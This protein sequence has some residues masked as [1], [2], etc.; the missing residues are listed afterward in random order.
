MDEILEWLKQ[1]SIAIASIPEGAYPE[2]DEYLNTAYYL[3]DDAICQLKAIV[4]PEA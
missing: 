4:E 3:L 2:I 1:A